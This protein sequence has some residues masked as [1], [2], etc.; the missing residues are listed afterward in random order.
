MP[1]TAPPNPLDVIDTE[2]IDAT[3]AAMEG[4]FAVSA[5]AAAA[6]AGGVGAGGVLL[7]VTAGALLTY[8]LVNWKPWNNFWVSA[9]A[10][11][12]DVWHK[13]TN[14]LFGGGG[15]SLDTVSQMIQFAN[16]VQMRAARQLFSNTFG[17]VMAGQAG[18][19]AAMRRLTAVVRNNALA[20]N[21]MFSYAQ[22]FALRVGQSIEARAIGREA[23]ILQ[24]AE[25]Y[26]RAIVQQE[27]R[28]ATQTIVAPLQREI[29]SLRG[30]VASLMH[31]QQ[32][33]NLKINKHIIP[34]VTLALATA[35]AAAKIANQVR[36]WVDD[37]GEPMCQTQGPKTDWGKLFRKFGPKALWLLLAAV[38]ASDPQEV[39]KLAEEFGQT[40]GPILAHWTEGYLGLISGGISSDVGTV[41]KG[42]GQF[43][44]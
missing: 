5:T 3:L 27:I 43:T 33:Q 42:V 26:A 36:T 34:E 10:K 2:F 16:H 24:R 17:R 28:A 37:C 25:S 7:V 1:V 39:E 21:Q 6:G 30:E 35:T 31:Q 4:Q 9:G 13:A 14:F 44:L 18:L 38:A 20:T 11:L 41:G 32:L 29:I 12:N 23:A 19:V 15:V 22:S 40:F 8:D